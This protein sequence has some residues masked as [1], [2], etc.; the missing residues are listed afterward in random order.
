MSG[1]QQMMMGVAGATAALIPE[2]R[3]IGTPVEGTSATIV[4]LPA[5]WAEND[6]FLMF[7]EG[8][9]TDTVTVPSGWAQVL[10]SPVTQSSGL[11]T[12]LTMLWKRATASESDVALADVGDHTYAVIAAYMNCITTGDPWNI[13][14]AAATASSTAMSF[15]SATTTLPNC[16]VINACAHGTDATAARFGAF[17]NANLAGLTKRLDA[18]TTQG[19]GGGLA[20]SDG[21]LAAAG[22]TGNT[23][24]TATGSTSTGAMTVA[25]KGG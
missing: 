6:I 10:G 21:L 1:I 9:D 16:L 5:G 12:E 15:P 3:S 7:V 22:T 24:A 23:T 17:T 25:L 4:P 19:N 8:S 14:A 2:F 13:T 20:I 18:G 11:G